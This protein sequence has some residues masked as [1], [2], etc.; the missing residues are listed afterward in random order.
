MA[1]TTATKVP[2][3]SDAETIMNAAYQSIK[4]QFNSPKGWMGVKTVEVQANPDDSNSKPETVLVKFRKDH[5]ELYRFTREIL[6]LKTR[7]SVGKVQTV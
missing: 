2:H 3:G 5:A 6:P 4:S 7:V 1:R